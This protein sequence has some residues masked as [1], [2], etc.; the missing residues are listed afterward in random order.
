MRNIIPV[1]MIITRKPRQNS[2]HHFG[3]KLPKE[4]KTTTT[5]LKK[6]SPRPRGKSVIG[7]IFQQIIRMFEYMMKITKSV[8][9]LLKCQSK[10]INTAENTT[11]F[12]DKL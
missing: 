5:R 6:F 8:Q 11:I 9:S 4:Q 10:A 2:D 7:K 3:R 12:V 1:V